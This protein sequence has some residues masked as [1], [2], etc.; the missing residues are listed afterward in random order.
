MKEKQTV[1]LKEL[2]RRIK[3]LEADNK[4]LRNDLIALYLKVGSLE[5]LGLPNT[6]KKAPVAP[7]GVDPWGGP[8]P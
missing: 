1:K 4:I 8:S 2:K 6:P 7:L 5:A 3:D